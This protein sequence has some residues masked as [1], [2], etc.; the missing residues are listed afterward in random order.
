MQIP[1]YGR[2]IPENEESTLIR[3]LKTDPLHSDGAASRRLQGLF[4][5][6][7]GCEHILLTPS[8]S[9]SLELACRLLNLQPGEEVILP[10]FNFPSAAN[11]VL[12]A[13][14]RPVLCDIDP[15]TQT[16]CLADVQRKIT[17]RTR[18]VI[19]VH[20]AGLSCD[21]D[22]LLALAREARIE[23][24][25]DAAQAVGAYY[26][27]KPLGT[28]GRF[29]CYSFHSTKNISCGEG[30]A[31]ICGSRDVRAAQIFRDK[32]TNRCD[33]LA[34]EA[35]RY[36]WVG[37]GSSPVLSEVSCALLLCQ[38]QAV[39]EITAKRNTLM[40][41]YLDVLRPLQTR[42]SAELMHIPDYA[43]GNGH[44]FYIRLPSAALRERAMALL[45]GA[46]V[47][48]RT[49]YVPLHLSP[50]GEKL[51]YRPQDL[52]HSLHTGDTLLRLP[53]HTNMNE[54]HIR[55]VAEILK[56]VD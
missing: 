27:G 38:M 34:R 4:R 22:A 40:H 49:H 48:A 18:A 3:L 31:L 11:A 21:M 24:I 6:S 46:G 44:L 32:G 33:Y 56:R 12:L 45:L 51:G 30:G 47:D 43:Q 1:F 50:M 35:A 39:R 2:Y 26:R 55:Y 13:G 5:E 41:A 19:A 37:V 14:G 28:L 52:P 42:G 53:L 29:G 9:H 36:T 17:K 10:S 8:C 25:E 20:Y 16:L 15:R 23:V 54:S 7:F